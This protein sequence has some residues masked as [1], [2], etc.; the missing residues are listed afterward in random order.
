[1]R[2]RW[3]AGAAWALACLLAAAAA[4]AATQPRGRAASR[5][6]L[7]RTARPP[8]PPAAA[9]SP[10]ARAFAAGWMLQDTNG[11]GIA[12]AIRGTIVVPARPTAAENAAAANLAARLA[13]GSTGLTLPLVV[14]MPPAGAG[15]RI[16]VGRAATPPDLWHGVAPMAERLAPGEGG[17]FAAGNDLIIAGGDDQG[18]AAAAAG[19]AAH[20]PYIWDVP[21]AKLEAVASEVAGARVELAGL[22]YRTR[23]SG[24]ARAYLRGAA[25]ARSLSRALAQPALKQLAELAVIDGDRV[26]S[27]RRPGAATARKEG[28][29]AAKSNA[30]QAS[31]DAEPG[32][33]RRLDLATLYTGKGLFNPGKKVP[34]PASLDAQLCVPAGPAGVAMANLAARLGLETTGI[35]IPLA[36]P[37]PGADAVKLKTQ[38]VVAGN[39]PLARQAWAAWQRQT[40]AAMRAAPLGVGEGA[41]VIVDDVFPVRRPERAAGTG[42]NAADGGEPR[43]EHGAVLIRGDQAGQAAVLK[44]LAGRF[45]NLWDVG[46]Q[47]LSLE[48]IRYDLHRFFSLRSAAGQ[49][50]AALYHLDQWLRAIPANE[51]PRDVKAEIYVDLADPQLAAFAR[52]MIERDLRVTDAQAVAE[53]LRAGTR[54]C[55]SDPG[56]HYQNPDFPFHQARPTFA[57]DLT[58]P[59]EGRRLIEAVR[60]VVR[61][62]PR[63]EPVSLVAR[64]SEG[65]AERERLTRELRGLLIAAGA[66]P[67]RTRVEVL[68]AYKQ[69]YSWL[70]DEIAPELA[71]LPVRRIQIDFARDVDPTGV[72]V[73]YSPARWV[74][75]LYPVDEMLARKLN[76]PLSAIALREMPPSGVAPVRQSDSTEPG[77]L[78]AS[79]IPGTAYA[80]NPTYRV[81]AYDAAGRE[82]FDRSFTVTT[83]M[84]PYNGVMPRYE[85]VQVETGWVTMTAGPAIVLDKRIPTDLE[86]F[87]DHYQNVTLPR[88]YRIV[89]TQAHGWLRPEF[90]PPFDTLKLDIRMSEPDYDLGLDHERISSL[91][92]LQEDAF[93]S[94]QAFVHMMG[95][96]EAGRPLDYT[97]RIVPVVHPSADGEDGRVRIEFYAKAAANPLVRLSWRDG[98]GA[99]HVEERNLPPIGGA[100]EPRLIGVRVRAGADGVERLT[101]SLPADFL[102][103]DYA[104][105]LKVEGQDQVDRTIFSVAQAEGQM[106]WLAAM[107]AAGLYPD[108][109]A[110][111]HLRQLGFEFVLPRP[112]RAAYAAPADANVVVAAA[113][114]DPP[115]G[116][117]PPAPRAFALLA[118]PA[119]KHPRPMIAAFA[120]PGAGA[121]IVSWDEPIGNG[122][123]AAILARLARFP[124]VTVYW[125]GRSYLGND[126]WAA[127]ILLPSPSRLRSWAKETT[128]KATI[129]YSGR[130]HA[131]EVSSTSHIDKLGELLVADPAIRARLRRVNV[132]LHPIDNPDGTAL[133]MLLARITP[134]NL[135][136]PG[137]HGA[138]AADVAEGQGETDPVYP[139]SRTRRQLL[140][141]W[142]P[143]A[144]LNPHGYPSHEWVQPF[145]EYTGWVQSRE[146]ANPGRAWW[147][148]RGWFTSL[149]YLRDPQH[150]YA[151]QIAYALRDRIASAERAVPGLLPLEAR[152][153]DRYQRF[154]QR[155]QPRDM[156][157]PIVDGIRVY[158]ALKG[159]APRNGGVGGL[160]P[161]VTWDSG[162]TEAPDETAR[163]P[164]LHL[165]A[166]AGLA[167]DMVHLDL[168]ADGKLRIHRRESPDQDKVKFT[169]ERRR[170]ILP[171]SEPPLS[172]AVAAVQQALAAAVSGQLAAAPSS[173]SK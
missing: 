170:P 130:Q 17:V 80:G 44:L 94:T 36:I 171:D 58:I 22:V 133:S 27:V 152:M 53:S 20:A 56:L 136:H 168:L 63:G 109:I 149:G 49:A 39:S 57:E 29:G 125:M 153:N 50:S 68:C 126:I 86:M 74:Q 102:G 95:D 13:Y 145:S 100:M 71:R 134:E 11:N 98:S 172:A 141:A 10:L 75:E 140:A 144:F 28:A 21:G 77:P 164:Y 113:G 143:D 160:S 154:G 9:A 119:P 122:A 142:L 120:R 163:G 51:Q 69:G 155:F 64:V 7:A 34:V 45:P 48:E 2:R 162:Y 150:P 70:M 66:D 26:I 96:L 78:F 106:R 151:E 166:S 12:D 24:V 129:I 131:N 91:E 25:T 99:L 114:G 105:W 67:Q 85:Q 118:V 31:A 124:G 81:H 5:A 110:Y 146:S 82:I 139:E 47:Y 107:H 4:T 127:D 103:D 72:R 90:Q 41:A 1:M 18:L 97:G 159:S 167:F 16:F 148:P 37:A 19:F 33:S 101:W 104:A 30:D 132:V 169:L 87:W 73:M 54:C 46:K 92:A 121:P 60:G 112:I 3:A 117:L 116:A 157:Q 59:W 23:G 158:M 138:L 15:P 35:E 161:D 137:Y 173:A 76:L 38:A 88:V 62:I 123:N 115:G 14:A 42:T 128:L 6:V 8:A 55:A 43:G 61:Q 147:I 52:R 93:Y 165:L 40:A 32:P 89:M 135:L 83:A 65:P 84:Q 108:A 79:P 111:P 156:F